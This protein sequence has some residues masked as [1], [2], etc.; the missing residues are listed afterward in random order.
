MD[1]LGSDG[2]R[3]RKEPRMCPCHF[4]PYLGM[5]EVTMTY[6]CNRGRGGGRGQRGRW[7]QNGGGITTVV[8]N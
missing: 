4:P 3:D 1:G 2:P 7:G 8:T 5:H 6:A